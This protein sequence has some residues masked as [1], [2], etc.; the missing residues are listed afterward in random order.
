MYIIYIYRYIRSFSM[1][2][3][4]NLIQCWVDNKILIE[5]VQIS[6]IHRFKVSTSTQTTQSQQHKQQLLWSFLFLCSHVQNFEFFHLQTK[7]ISLGIPTP[8]MAQTKRWCSLS[9]ALRLGQGLVS[10][11]GPVWISD[12]VRLQEKN[13]QT[14]CGQLLHF[15][16]WFVAF[17]K[18]N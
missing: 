2:F 17:K 1:I 16:S 6:T 3:S 5:F 13:K 4:W 8:A 9:V 12:L 18:K 10:S 7:L 11:R 15:N 14:S